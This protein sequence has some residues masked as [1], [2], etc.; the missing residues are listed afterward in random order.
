[1]NAERNEV[2]ASGILIEIRSTTSPCWSVKTHGRWG[3]NQR[4]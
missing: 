1:M 2:Q 3:N 4:G